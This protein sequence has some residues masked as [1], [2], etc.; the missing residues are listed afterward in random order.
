MSGETNSDFFLLLESSRK[1]QD[2]DNLKAGIF[3]VDK[4]RNIL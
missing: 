3:V 2:Q 4:I 1:Q